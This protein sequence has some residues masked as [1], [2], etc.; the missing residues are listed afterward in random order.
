MQKFEIFSCNYMWN[1]AQTMPSAKDIS[2]FLCK[3]QQ[4]H[5]K[6]VASIK[7]SKSK[8]L[9]SRQTSFHS[10]EF[11]CS[12][13]TFPQ[14]KIPIH[15]FRSKSCPNNNNKIEI[16]DSKSDSVGI[17]ARAGLLQEFYSKITKFVVFG[18]VL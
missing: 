3:M 12:T 9:F 13:P 11:F 10:F 18:D 5:K 16:G 8:W 7:K 14:E 15:R 17:S 6:L 4:R 2:S 1:I